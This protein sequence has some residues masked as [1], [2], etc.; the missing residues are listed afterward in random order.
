MD[1]QPGSDSLPPSLS[2]SLSLSLALSLSLSLSLALSRSRSLA[3][4]LSLCVC[5]LYAYIQV[6]DLQPGSV[7]VTLAVT[8]GR[9]SAADIAKVPLFPLFFFFSFP[10]SSSYGW[11]HQRR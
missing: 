11:A 6:V 10:D 1:L 2:L 8:G 4:S 3:L 7:I 9:I 5:N